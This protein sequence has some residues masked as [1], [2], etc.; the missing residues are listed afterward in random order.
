MLTITNSAAEMLKNLIKENGA[1]GLQAFMAQSC[2]S[3]SPAF[4]M[5]R[6]EEGDQP[7][8]INEIP[9][10]MDDDV[11]GEIDQAIID[12][13]DGE[14]AVFLPAAGGCG[15]GGHHHHDHEEGGCCGGHHHDHEEGGCC[16]GHHHDDEEGSCCG[17]HGH[18]GGCCHE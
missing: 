18:D 15:C 10:L 17:T 1:D 3:A 13:A 12:V 4:Q 8:I 11:K 16:G 6:F 2:C 7:E 14:L 9:V 5:V